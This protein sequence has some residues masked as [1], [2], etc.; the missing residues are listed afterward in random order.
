MR[1][2][3]E[4]EMYRVFGGV[5]EVG[6]E[7][8][9]VDEIHGMTDNPATIL[10]RIPGKLLSCTG[11]LGG[12]VWT[13][14]GLRFRDGQGIFRHDGT[15]IRVTQGSGKI[16]P[17]L[18]FDMPPVPDPIIPPDPPG[19]TGTGKGNVSN[20]PP[21]EWWWQ[22]ETWPKWF[23]PPVGWSQ[24]Q[25]VKYPGLGPVQPVWSYLSFDLPTTI[26][27]NTW[28]SVSTFSDYCTSI[29]EA[30]PPAVTLP[31][32]GGAAGTWNHEFWLQNNGAQSYP[33]HLSTDFGVT[34]TDVP[35][36][37]V[38][39]TYALFPAWPFVSPLVSDNGRVMV[40]PNTFKT[41][42]VPPWT[43][44]GVYLSLDSG[45]TWSFILA[46]IDDSTTGAYISTTG[47][48]LGVLTGSYRLVLSKD[49]GSTWTPYVPRG[50]VNNDTILAACSDS[51]DVVVSATVLYDDVGDPLG[52]YGFE[53]SADS[54]A[55][56]SISGKTF[57]WDTYEVVSM[58][59]S[60]QGGVCVLLNVYDPITYAKIG[61]EVWYSPDLGIVWERCVFNPI[62]TAVGEVQSIIHVPGTSQMYA[63]S[64]VGTDV[65][66]SQFNATGANLSLTSPSVT[67]PL[68]YWCQ[69]LEP[70]GLYDRGL[71]LSW[72]ASWLKVRSGDDHDLSGYVPSGSIFHVFELV[73][74]VNS[75]PI[76]LELDSW[77]ATHLAPGAYVTFLTANIVD[78]LYARNTD[79]INP[80]GI[81]VEQTLSVRLV[82]T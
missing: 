14:T 23:V 49:F 21:S 3:E 24:T 55:T 28:I 67:V 22:P 80:D 61:Q 50:N 29:G 45:S 77:E 51:G 53:F 78:T 82:I 54:G 25:K 18:V 15:T 57:S 62:A 9:L 34:W 72:S 17:G 39:L 8:S 48:V 30:V 41:L 36:L 20:F 64:L 43:E 74:A 12:P 37:G 75:K 32:Y 58:S 6:K 65:Y 68:E 44:V 7:E 70:Y 19:S 27:W 56:F 73:P 35:G 76:I 81:L 47:N 4:L 13:L 33:V 69:P 10:K 11:S 63:Q 52:L 71:R 31:D 16:A 79:I 2:E 5:H 42:T 46:D 60:D 38:F 66:G 26:P 1:T 59:V 40:L